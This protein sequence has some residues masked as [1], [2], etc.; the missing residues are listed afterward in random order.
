MTSTESGY[1]QG[2]YRCPLLTQSN[3]TAWSSAIQVQMTAEQCWKIVTGDYT[4][5]DEPVL[6]PATTRAALIENRQLQ[7][8]Y[9]ADVAAYEQRGGMAAAIIRSSLTPAAESYVKGMQD[10]I[11]MWET[12]KEKL[13]PQGNP[14]LQQTISS[15]F[16]ALTFDGKED[17]TIFIERLRDYQYNLT[18]SHL[19]ISDSR[20]VSKLLA[21]LPLTWKSQ[22]R[23][24][25]GSGNPTLATIEK[26]LRNLQ[27]ELTGT[28]SSTATSS[29]AFAVTKPGGRRGR[30]H[31]GR[32]SQGSRGKGRGN[33]GGNL[34]TSGRATSTEIQ[35][36]Y[37]T[38]KGHKQDE[39]HFKKQADA[40]R[41][42]RNEKQGKGGEKRAGNAGDGPASAA[43][44]AMAT[45]TIEELPD[46]YPTDA[47]AFMAH[48]T[49]TTLSDGWYIDSGATDHICYDRMLFAD[50]QPLLTP[51]PVFLGN[52]SR[53]NAYGTGTVHLGNRITLTG[54]LHVPDM[55]LNLFSVEKALC[56]GY[57]LAFTP[58]GCTISHRGKAIMM[59]TR[60]GNLFRITT[61]HS[62]A[63]LTQGEVSST[64][65]AASQPITRPPATLATD[66]SHSQTLQLWHERLGHLNM[67]DIRRLAGMANGI[68]SA[69]T[70]DSAASAS[71]GVCPACLEG[72]QN[73]IFNRRVPAS[74]AEAPLALIHSDSCG[75]F[76]TA[77]I[78][79]AK[80]FILFVDDYT[81]MTWV[82]FL[83][84]KGHQEVLGAFQAFKAAMEKHSG[85]SI[86]RLRCDNGRGEYSN[87]FFLSYL[88]A[89][90]ISFEPSAPYTQHQNGVSERKIRS[91]VEKAR[92]MLLEARLPARFWAE[93][94]NTAVYLLNRSPTRALENKT[95]F[96]AWHGRMPILSHLR[97]FGC[98]A[99][100][101]VPDALRSKLDSKTR[102]CTLLG[103]VHNTTK[104]WRL[105]DVRRQTVVNG[106]SVRFDEAGFGSRAAE[107]APILLE[108]ALGEAFN[109]GEADIGQGERPRNEPAEPGTGPA[110]SDVDDTAGGRLTA[111][112]D[113]LLLP[114]GAPE[115]TET[116]DMASLAPGGDS[117]AVL[118]DA[119]WVPSQ[120]PRRSQRIQARQPP[121]ASHCMA[122]RAS[123]RDEPQTLTEA[124]DRD[125]VEWRKAVEDELRSHAEN[126]TWEPAQLPPGRDAISSKWVFKTKVNADGSLRYKA[127][128]VVRGFEQREGLDYQETFAPVAK[129][130]TV[131]VLLALAAH[132]DWEVHQMD[133]KKA[134][135]Y[136]KLQES[137]YMAPPE[138]YA[139]FTPSPPAPIPTMLRL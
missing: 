48:G 112:D 102:R 59:A 88:T 9:A 125:P 80:Y 68:P 71:S 76:R 138:G 8:D 113:A 124:L 127:R 22:I 117:S 75:P 97:R 108:E 103:Y 105:W 87:Q 114:G 121:R 58:A 21:S 34:G 40:L 82:H 119:E 11:Q 42:S 32:G 73:R 130:T 135:L 17:I 12:L 63:N 79:G 67:A 92:T 85:R 74:H 41:K 14:A 28:G 100:L 98:D 20:L 10:P 50:Y 91:I 122:S 2:R 131:R 99:Y 78:A 132:F 66:N 54:V 6:N 128:L 46:D 70:H 95:P 61:Q 101:H 18:G 36:W 89:E 35:C 137:V 134:F 56:R 90:G 39:C 139:E 52:S 62:L 7:R 107:E 120:I 49:Y 26:E 27:A 77:S 29:R 47:H 115:E 57:E 106:A 33:P 126:E 136:P 109:A 13:A 5:P 93:A 55:E 72:K 83:H 116:N 4:M 110:A 69:F 45:G 84:T 118:W 3:Y 111:A 81:R 51:R 31:G 24:L 1:T 65:D 94:V 96:E 16:D 129:F 38:R 104:L 64:D 53:V 43:N 86:L 30:G 133:V 15:E 44:I 25:M 123:A 37:C 23:H 60:S 19:S